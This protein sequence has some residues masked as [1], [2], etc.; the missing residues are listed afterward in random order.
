MKN[1]LF[2]SIIVL[3]AGLFAAEETRWSACTYQ[4]KRMVKSMTLHFFQAFNENKYHEIR[5]MI[6]PV[7][8][9][10]DGQIWMSSPKFLYFMGTLRERGEIRFDNIRAYT[11]DDC[12]ADTGIKN[13]AL[14]MYRVFDNR[15]ILT[16][17]DLVYT[18]KNEKS[19]G[20][21][22]FKK[23]TDNGIWY[24]A[25]ISGFNAQLELPA[26]TKPG[27]DED[28]REEDI[29]QLK[30][31]LPMYS[32]FNK[33]RQYDTMIAYYVSGL[34]EH[35]AALQVMAVKTGS[36]ALE[37]GYRFVQKI[38]ETRKHTVVRIKYLPA[39]YWF[40]SEVLDRD[41]KENKMI[42]VSFRNKKRVII[43]SLLAYMKIYEEQWK[44][45]EYTLRNV[46]PY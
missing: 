9:N 25:A 6:D 19:R 23:S 39:G 11:F 20:T 5:K 45:M 43:V 13:N 46:A 27:K 15:S 2:L 41:K 38:L 32:S 34:T 33:K 22:L 16:I 24:I 44:E 10:F 4:D 14:G 28:W 26:T 8:M 40:E 42:V 35:D 18:R 37:E 17:S 29:P 3:S 21:L 31:T 30:I 7:E 12:E 1:I 36:P